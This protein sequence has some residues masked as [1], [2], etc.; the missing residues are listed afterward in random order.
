[1]GVHA[2]AHGSGTREVDLLWAAPGDRC[3]LVPVLDALLC[4]ACTGLKVTEGAAGGGKDLGGLP[5][6]AT[7]R[8]ERGSI[9]IA[10]AGSSPTAA[11]SG[12]LG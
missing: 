9:C 10:E 8:A 2:S 5:E 3:C 11:G 1:M 7:P 4:A 12:P 6:R